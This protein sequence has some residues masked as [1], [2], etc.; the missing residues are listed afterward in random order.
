MQDLIQQR[1]QRKDSDAKDDIMQSLAGQNH[2][3]EQLHAAP[4]YI[5][6]GEWTELE[7]TLRNSSHLTFESLQWDIRPYSFFNS[8]AGLVRAALRV[9]PR[10]ARKEITRAISAPAAKTHP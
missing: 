9:W 1:R 2:L 7:R 5:Q 10:T 8:S 6:D 3:L 4:R